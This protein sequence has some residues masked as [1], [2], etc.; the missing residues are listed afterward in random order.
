MHLLAAFILLVGLVTGLNLVREKP[1]PNPDIKVLPASTSDCRNADFNGDNQ[2]NIYDT[3]LIGQNFNKTVP[4]AEEKYDLS[5]NGI[6]DQAD[7]ELVKTCFGQNLA[8][9]TA[10]PSPTP[11][12]PDK[13][14]PT[15]GIGTPTPIAT[16]IRFPTPTPIPLP[17]E[18]PL[19]TPGLS[20]AP[21]TQ[22]RYFKYTSK[23]DSNGSF[24]VKMID[25]TTIQQALKDISEQRLI[26]GGIVNAGNGG[27]NSPWSW[28]L[29]PSTIVLGESFVEACDAQPSYVEA[30]LTDWLGKMYCPWNA[31]ISSEV[32]P[33]VTNS[34]PA[35]F[36]PSHLTRQESKPQTSGLF[37]TVNNFLKKLF[38]L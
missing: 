3:I 26:V 36:S 30:H 19:H 7:L 18:P 16:P 32:S 1:L 31:R 12:P 17:T 14:E 5:H 21:I 22:A 28:H 8:E 10:P 6:I 29:D 37:N 35:S 34:T 20:P 27:F 23:G 24:I 33:S 38:G 15:I 25:Q 4:P 2:V 13:P 11:Q 9:P